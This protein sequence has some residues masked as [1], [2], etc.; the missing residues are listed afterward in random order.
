LRIRGGPR[1][2]VKRPP[3]ARTGGRFARRCAQ[4][5]WSTTSRYSPGTE[6]APRSSVLRSRRRRSSAA[7]SGVLQGGE[8]RTRPLSPKAT[9]RILRAKG[10]FFPRLVSGAG[11]SD[12]DRASGPH[13]PFTESRNSLAPARAETS[14]GLVRRARELGSGDGVRPPHRRARLQLEQRA[15]AARRTTTRHLGSPSRGARAL[16]AVSA[17]Q[18]RVYR[19]RRGAA[20]HGV[21][22][23]RLAVVADSAR[24]PSVRRC[25]QPRVAARHPRA[26]AQ[27]RV[28][29]AAPQSPVRPVRQPADRVA[30]GRDLSALSLAPPCAAGGRRSRHGSA[31]RARRA[32]VA[33]PGAEARVDGVSGPL[34][35]DPPARGPA[36]QARSV[37]D[38]EFRR[39]ARL[40][41]APRVPLGVEGAA[42]PAARHHPGERI[43]PRRGALPVR[44]LRVSPWPGDVL[45]LRPAEPRHVQRRLPQRAPRFP[46]HSRVTVA[47]TPAA[48]KR[49]LRSA[50]RASLL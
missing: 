35:C 2:A 12:H 45:V 48:G 26:L 11:R 50:P 6:S 14:P 7:S 15:G 9:T 33:H 38:R 5:L 3:A 24:G 42:L 10:S 27:S 8:R 37:G 49:V 21:P 32:S 30:R 40:R 16:R 4:C 47:A 20:R 18:V 34:L 46:V 43:T 39:A 44:A 22:L 23:A 1:S 29:S 13:D 17:N 25:E 36:A 19:A 28:P 31:Y 41:R